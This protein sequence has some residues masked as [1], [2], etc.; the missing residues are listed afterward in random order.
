MI[1]PNARDRLEGLMFR[2]KF[3]LRL[4]FES[5][6]ADIRQIQSE[7]NIRHIRSEFK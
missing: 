3:C 7:F 2:A 4:E 6:H 5:G 1:W